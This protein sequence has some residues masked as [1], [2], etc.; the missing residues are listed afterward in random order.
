MLK[1]CLHST[2]IVITQA[3]LPMIALALLVPYF[4][5]RAEN[6][7]KL[8]VFLSDWNL[9]FL[10]THALFYCLIFFMWPAFVRHLCRRRQ[11]KINAS[12]LKQALSARWYLLSAF[13]LLELLMLWR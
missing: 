11:I 9:L 1:K 4:L 3:I 7:Q 12:E 10:S 13:I 5:K 6:L 2:I 8:Q